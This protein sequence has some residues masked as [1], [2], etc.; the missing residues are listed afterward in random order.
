MDEKQTGGPGDEPKADRLL[1]HDVDGIREYDNPLPR[2]WVNLFWATI[3][4]AVLYAANVIPG[5]GSGQGR[6]AGAEQQRGDAGSR[7]TPT[8]T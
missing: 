8:D 5:V 2:W 3:V 6:I 7:A 4:F 1:D